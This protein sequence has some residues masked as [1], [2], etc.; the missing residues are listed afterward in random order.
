MFLNLI[1]A[2]F[3]TVSGPSNWWSTP[4]VAKCCSDA[5]AV[6][7]DNWS[8]N[9]DGS[10][11]ATVTGRGPRNHDW[12]PVGRTYTIPKEKILNVPGNPTGR[13]LIF[14]NPYYQDHVYCFALGPLI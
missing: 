14:L 5:D 7:A 3:L 6:Y 8:I 9:P 4:E 1:L 13:P 11:T 12:A 10:V 2:T